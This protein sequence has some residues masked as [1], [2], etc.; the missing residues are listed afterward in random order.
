MVLLLYPHCCAMLL[1]SLTFILLSCFASWL[2]IR[3]LRVSGFGQGGDGEV[4]HHHTHTGV[5]PRIGGVGIVAGFG[6]AYL[7]WWF[8]HES[9]D[10][11]LLVHLAVL[12]GTC[13]AFLLGFIDDFRPLGAKLKLLGQILIAVFAYACGLAIEQVQLPFTAIDLDFGFLS[14]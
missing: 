6:V 8:Q 4:Q 1:T 12:G 2:V 14:L 13:A 9:G 7:L 3:L 10:P 5:I 11:K